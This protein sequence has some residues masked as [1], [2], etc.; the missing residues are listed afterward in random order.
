MDCTHCAHARPTGCHA[1]APAWPTDDVRGCIG[2]RPYVHVGGCHFCRWWRAGTDLC[3]RAGQPAQPTEQ[4]RNSRGHC[5]PGAS[6]WQRVGFDDWRAA[7]IRARL[8]L[9]AEGEAA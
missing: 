8:R 5:G 9:P 2:F 3:Q 4:A 1:E 7:D 6:A